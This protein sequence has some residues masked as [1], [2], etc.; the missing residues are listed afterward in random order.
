MVWARARDGKLDPMDLWKFLRLELDQRTKFGNILE[1]FISLNLIREQTSETC[2]LMEFP[3]SIFRLQKILS[4][5]SWKFTWKLLSFHFD[6]FLL[7]DTPQ[8]DFC[9]TGFF[10]FFNLDA[11]MFQ[12]FLSSSRQLCTGIR[13]R[14]WTPMILLTIFPLHS[15]V[16]VLQPRPR[17]ASYIGSSSSPGS[18]A[19]SSWSWSSSARSAPGTLHEVLVSMDAIQRKH[20]Q[21]L[22]IVFGEQS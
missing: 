4:Y 16:T 10:I 18:A 6:F 13:K 8:Q 21:V 9:P 1:T 19:P 22:S 15:F 11:W 12:P 7:E 17:A 14:S 5:L 20:H 3:G 2:T